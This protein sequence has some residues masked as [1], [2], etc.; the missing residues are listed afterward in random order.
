MAGNVLEFTSA[1]WDQ[2]V[3]GSGVPV[4]VDFWA[5]WCGPCR[6]L[7]PV[8]ERL[9][10]QYAGRVKVGKLNTDDNQDIAVNFGISSIPT[11]LFFKGGEQPRDRLVGV[12][13]EA[14]LKKMLDRLLEG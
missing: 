13:P 4:L 11:L 7:T 1:N 10:D 14:D 9:A 12:R 8:I 5:P 3:V 6:Q 2:E